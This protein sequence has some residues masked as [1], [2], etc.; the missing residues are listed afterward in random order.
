MQKNDI[1]EIVIKVL[2]LYL[3]VVVINQLRDVMMYA[4]FLMQSKNNV[5][6]SDVDQTPLFLI[7]VFS[8]LITTLF[9][10][11]LIFKTKNVV[12]II[13]RKEEPDKIINLISN[14]ENIYQV[15][16]TIIGFTI[17]VLTIPQFGVELK[18]YVQLIQNSTFVNSSSSNLLLI[19]GLK[20]VLGIAVIIYSNPIAVFLA[21][22]RNVR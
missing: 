20:V 21:K 12:K 9:A 11:F 16:T 6:L 4:S 15:A 17:I 10:G 7:S 1:F 19:S 18:N 5:S 8:F 2:G 13:S 3:V 14:K 22:E